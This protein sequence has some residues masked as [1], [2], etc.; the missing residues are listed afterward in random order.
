MSSPV[1][2]PEPV[3]VRLALQGGGAKLYALL[4]SLCAL[5]T[6]EAK[7]TIKVKE[8]AGTSAGAIAGALFAARLP[9]TDVRDWL[10]TSPSAARL[11]IPVRKAKNM[12]PVTQIFY[13]VRRKAWIPE[14]ALR[15]A[16]DGLFALGKLRPGNM[17]L[18]AFHAD[19]RIP[20]RSYATDLTNG[21]LVQHDN[22]IFLDEALCQSAGLPFVLKT[23]TSGNKEMVDGGICENL[24]SSFFEPRGDPVAAITFAPGS[25]QGLEKLAK[26]A[27]ALLNTAID[28]SVQRARN[29][30][31]DH[32]V[33]VVPTSLTLLDFDRYLGVPRSE[34]MDEE[35]NSAFKFALEWFDGFAQRQRQRDHLM[36]DPWMETRQQP[37]YWA[38]QCLKFMTNLERVYRAS[39]GHQKHLIRSIRFEISLDCGADGRLD[40]CE[41]YYRRTFAAQANQPIAAT[42]VTLWAP[43]TATISEVEHYIDVAASPPELIEMPIDENTLI[44]KYVEISRQLLMWTMPPLNSENGEATLHLRTKGKGLMPKLSKGGREEIAISTVLAASAVQ[45]IDIFLVLPAASLE[46]LRVEAKDKSADHKLR[47]Y[48]DPNQAS[49]I[50]RENNVSIKQTPKDALVH[51]RAESVERGTITGLDLKMEP[52]T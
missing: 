13:A 5:Q 27:L 11:A 29:S 1:V 24:P 50:C 6:L 44:D 48:A 3:S 39:F 52:M 25:Q 14:R 15:D 16:L 33:C 4:G 34:E 2:P 10:H 31:G 36:G 47:T 12:W 43:Q 8:V 19:D 28:H 32:N 49:V 45:S 38:D 21:R 41:V 22:E 18:S 35:W 20:F 42:K 9:M 30:L 26:Y 7:G 37:S 46:R 51:W 23:A 40:G 17:K